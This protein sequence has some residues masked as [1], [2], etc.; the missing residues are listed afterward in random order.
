MGAPMSRRT[1]SVSLNLPHEIVITAKW[2]DRVVTGVYRKKKS[3][4]ALLRTKEVVPDVVF[5]DGTA[6]TARQLRS[7]RKA[8]MA[9]QRKRR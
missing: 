8:R 4:L 2:S 7:L 6:A 3:I 5:V 9:K 1:V